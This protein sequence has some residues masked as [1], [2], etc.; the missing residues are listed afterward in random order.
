MNEEG[1]GGD[2]DEEA[3][4]TIVHDEARGEVV[5]EQTTEIAAGDDDD[6]LVGDSDVNS[7]LFQ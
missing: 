5:L 4:N 3:E 2:S 1:D 7:V 6:H